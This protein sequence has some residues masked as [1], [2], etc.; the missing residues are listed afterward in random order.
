M[1]KELK[2]H[3][4]AR[5]SECRKRAQGLAYGSFYDGYMECY[6][7]HEKEN[8][9]LRKIA[10]YQQTQNMERYFE[11]ER[12]RKTA[13]LNLDGWRKSDAKLEKA[14]ALLEKWLQT[15]HHYNA[16]NAACEE[17]VLRTETEQFLA[18]EK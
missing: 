4:E 5:Y 12:T 3:I 7:E 14:R 13:L 16:I 15:E 6:K 18:G 11:N 8:E 2:E 9:G 17:L 10:E 1:T